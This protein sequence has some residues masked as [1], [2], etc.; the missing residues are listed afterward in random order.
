MG[1]EQRGNQGNCA[2]GAGVSG[3]RIQCVER[4]KKRQRGNPAENFGAV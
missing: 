2:D 4:T 1:G 3:H